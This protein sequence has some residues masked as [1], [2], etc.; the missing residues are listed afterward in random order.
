MSIA[1]LKGLISKFLETYN[2]S[3]KDV[4]W[5]QHK[6]TFHQF[7]RDKVLAVGTGAITDDE[8]DVVIRVL[9]THGKGNTRGS[10]AVANVMM[11]QGAW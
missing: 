10:E 9:D 7:W 1:L 4:I 8:C 5:Q 2:P 11:P 6:E 3:A